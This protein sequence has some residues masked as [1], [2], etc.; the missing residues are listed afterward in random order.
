MICG[1]PCLYGQQ[2]EADPDYLT[3]DH[4]VPRSRGGDDHLSNLRPAHRRCNELIGNLTDE[5]LAS[6]DFD[7][8][9]A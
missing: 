2:H 4:I 6:G 9:V 7:W 3:L 8:A 1:E 5:E